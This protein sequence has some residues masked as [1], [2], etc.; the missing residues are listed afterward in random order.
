M[1]S[2]KVR[3][4]S[5]QRRPKVK[6]MKLFLYNLSADTAKQVKIKNS[7]R[8]PCPSSRPSGISSRPLALE[9]RPRRMRPPPTFLPLPPLAETRPGPP[10]WP[11]RRRR[12]LRASG[13]SSPGAAPG[14]GRWCRRG[15]PRGP[16]RW[17][18]WCR[19]PPPVSQR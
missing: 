13:P 14:G 6:K 4:S 8:S 5:V 3:Q 10:G 19:P 7:P 2:I 17:P 12:T 1:G 15:P 9:R 16:S 18:Q 11:R